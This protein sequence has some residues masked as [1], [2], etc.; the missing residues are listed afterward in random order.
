M[1]S[2]DWRA[3]VGV[4]AAIQAA[5]CFAYRPS[6]PSRVRIGEVVRV[7]VNHHGAQQLT[8]QVGPRVESLA[9]RVIHPRDTALVVS[10]REVTRSRGSEEFWT[11][12]SVSV[13]L[14]GVGGVSV[15]RF[16]RNRTLLTVTGAVIGIALLRRVIDDASLAGAPVRQQPGSQ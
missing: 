1:T 2:C 11:G 8:Q 13:P 4:A 6:D 7:A 16:D 14:S 9:G 10:V 5:G 15:R 12:E 3:V